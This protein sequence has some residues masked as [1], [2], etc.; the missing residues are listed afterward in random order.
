MLKISA[1]RKLCDQ[2]L[3]DGLQPVYYDTYI[4][5]QQRLDKHIQNLIRGA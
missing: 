3:Y 5:E 4:E 1:Q 2:E